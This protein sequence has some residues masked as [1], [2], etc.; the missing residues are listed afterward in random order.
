M[1]EKENYYEDDAFSAIE[2]K[3]L[4]EVIK[5]KYLLK[6]I[7]YDLDGKSIFKRVHRFGHKWFFIPFVF[8]I[9]VFNVA[10]FFINIRLLVTKPEL[11]GEDE[12][13][14]RKLT[15]VF[16]MIDILCVLILTTLTTVKR[17]IN[18]YIYY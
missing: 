2:R 1:K 14:T 10:D 15:L 5:E 18:T 4:K 9:F 3:K 13:F 12:D 6:R 8:Y 7:Y 16:N 11:Y 17:K